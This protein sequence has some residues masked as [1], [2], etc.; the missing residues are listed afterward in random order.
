MQCGNAKS[1]IVNILQKEQILYVV[2]KD[3]S[4]LS[5]KKQKLKLTSNPQK[6]Y[7][8]YIHDILTNSIDLSRSSTCQNKSILSCHHLDNLIHI[9]MI[10][11]CVPCEP[12]F[13]HSETVTCLCSCSD[14]LLYSA[15][16]DGTI[17]KWELISNSFEL[18]WASLEH[19][20]QISSLDANPTLDLVASVCP[21]THSLNLRI[22]S[23]NR[24]HLHLSLD[25][26]LKEIPIVRLSDR[27]YILIVARDCSSSKL[28]VYSVNGEFINESNSRIPHN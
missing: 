11:S 27:G 14:N 15:S 4:L 7:P 10:G 28:F 24:L 9:S 1:F 22:I 21:S 3:G 18:L 20:G 23:T 13:C 26:K 25:P 12:L 17:A 8:A 5:I 19:E 6:L 2:L 16:K